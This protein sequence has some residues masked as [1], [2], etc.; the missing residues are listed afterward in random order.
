MISLTENQAYSSDDIA[1]DE[2]TFVK[3][4][5]ELPIWEFLSLSKS[6]YLRLNNDEK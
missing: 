5:K 1:I 4:M 3:L 2:A 6:D